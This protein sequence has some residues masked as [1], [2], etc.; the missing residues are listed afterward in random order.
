MSYDLKQV[1]VIRRDLKMRQGKACSQSGHASGEF[2]KEQLLAI[3]DGGRLTL[4][5][6]EIAWMRGGMAKVTVRTDSEEQFNAIRDHALE[7][8]LKVRV[9]T[10][11]GRTEFHGV[12]TVTVLA[13]GP[14]R[15]ETID[16]VTSGLTLL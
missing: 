3:L 4:T 2:M 1:I 13:I 8:G 15:V 12:P 10:D 5:A 7:L 6:D 9:I 16:K 14:D 11:S